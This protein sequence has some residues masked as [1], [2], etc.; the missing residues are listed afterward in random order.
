M[1]KIVARTGYSAA[2]VKEWL[3]LEGV[4]DLVL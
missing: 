2:A 1:R 3:E 4:E